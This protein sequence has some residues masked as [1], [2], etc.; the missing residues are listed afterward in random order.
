M[1]FCKHMVKGMEC[2]LQEKGHIGDH[3]FKGTR[4]P[5]GDPV[6]D[7][8]QMFIDHAIE[9]PITDTVYGIGGEQYRQGS[10]D[11]ARNIRDAYLDLEVTS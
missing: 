8:I 3:D 1:I 6:L 9:L 2:S 5:S 7:M 11:T 4:D 10:K